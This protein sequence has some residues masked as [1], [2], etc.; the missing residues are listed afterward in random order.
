MTRS[1]SLD[2]SFPHRGRMGWAARLW[3]T[4]R[5]K[6]LGLAGVT[7]VLLVCLTALLADV[8]APYDPVKVDSIARLDAPSREHLLGT[9][10][11]GRDLLSRM[12]YG[13]RV[14]LYVSF[15]TVIISTII[16][17]LV[18]VVSG[19]LGGKM[20]LGLQRIVDGF[21]AFPLLLIA[22]LVVVTLGPSVS[23]LIA[24][25]S[26]STFAG[27][28]RVARGVTLSIREEDYVLACRAIGAGLPRIIRVHVLPNVFPHLIVLAT[29]SFGGIIL[30]ESSLSFLG[31]GVPPPNPTWGGI[32]GGE[33]V[34]YME[35]AP[36]LSVV[37]G[38]ALTIVVLGFNLGG[39]ALRDI[40]DPRLRGSQ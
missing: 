7:V 19:Y 12:M 8:A 17:A 11:L 9:D 2:I 18:G 39:D 16:G 14:S 15:G 22:M 29:A 3:K 6:P 34:K 30:A 40:L 28:A 35:K 32:L 27:K 37:P 38:L 5:R 31:F 4:W 20:D 26:L 25:L 13:A 33:G 23:S 1:Q 10:G 21:Q 24:A 36:W